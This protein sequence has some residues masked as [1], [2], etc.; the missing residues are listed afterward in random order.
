MQLMQRASGRRPRREI[1]VPG[2][3]GFALRETRRS[4]WEFGWHFHP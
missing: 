4:H 2:D 1:I 3:A